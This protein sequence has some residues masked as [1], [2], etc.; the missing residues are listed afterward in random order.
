MLSYVGSGLE[1]EPFYKHLPPRAFSFVVVV[2]IIANGGVEKE[3][4]KMDKYD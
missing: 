3:E 4:K 1:L 2:V